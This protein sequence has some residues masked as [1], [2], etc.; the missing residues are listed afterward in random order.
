MA[1]CSKCGKETGYDSSFCQ[2]CGAP[3]SEQSGNQNSNYNSGWANNYGPN[4]A[5]QQSA[6]GLG[7]TLT[8]ILVLGILWA[9]G[10]IIDGILLVAGGGYFLSFGGT[11]LIFFGILS[12]VSGAFA[13]MSCI[14]I[15]KQEKHNEAFLFCLIGSIIALPF[16]VGIVGIIF[17]FLL[18]KEKYRFKS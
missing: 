2:S 9:I 7:G 3:T 4:N 12:I 18:N 11:W 14:Y 17:A 1:Y 15:Y 8:I 10:A 5:P 13:L 16:V 6:Q